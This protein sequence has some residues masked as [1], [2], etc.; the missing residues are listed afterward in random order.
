[1]LSTEGSSSQV[2]KEILT[3]EDLKTTRAWDN[4][5]LDWVKGTKGTV[6]ENY[7]S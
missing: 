6:K 4:L 1:V 7:G 3:S 5:S 2:G